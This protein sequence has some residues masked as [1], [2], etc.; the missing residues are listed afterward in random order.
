M[1][2]VRQLVARQTHRALNPKLP[3]WTVDIWRP[4]RIGTH[5]HHLDFLVSSVECTMFKRLGGVFAVS[6]SLFEVALACRG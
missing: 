2:A 3:R 6:A 1:H 5:G 4:C